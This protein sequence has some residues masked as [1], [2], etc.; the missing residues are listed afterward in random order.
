MLLSGC[1]M[2][3]VSWFIIQILIRHLGVSRCFVRFTSRRVKLAIFKEHQNEVQR[4]RIP[5]WTMD[6]F[7]Q[8][9]WRLDPEH[10]FI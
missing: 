10:F 9:K 1:C 6:K 5:I 3:V 8:R 7:P 4:A 2:Y